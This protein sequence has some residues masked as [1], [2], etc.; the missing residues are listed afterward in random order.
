MP[1]LLNFDQINAALVSVR[2]FFQKH[3]K[4]IT[5]PK[6]LTG[7]FVFP[8]QKL[9]FLFNL[10]NFQINLLE[11]NIQL[12]QT[13]AQMSEH[14][15]CLTILAETNCDVSTT[16]KQEHSFKSN[17]QVNSKNADGLGCVRSV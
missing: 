16:L 7:T 5:D 14:I 8:I 10:F 15:E 1:A 9:H 4:I 2:D 17:L 13:T 12:Q 6:L 11:E 3:Y